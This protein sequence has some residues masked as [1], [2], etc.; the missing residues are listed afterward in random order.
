[1]KKLLL[2]LALALPMLAMTSCDDDDKVPN[3]DVTVS[4]EG[5]T[6]V[7]NTLYLVK[8]QP[9][10]ITAVT[11]KDLGGKGAVI[12]GVNYFWDYFRIGASIVSPYSMEFATEGIPAGNHLLQMTM[13]IYAVDYSPCEALL[14]YKVV[15][16]ESEDDIPSDG[17]IE[18]DPVLPASVHAIDTDDD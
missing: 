14:E 13:S 12:G 8:D 17:D 16:V 10:N 11:L 5:T 6:R 2:L 1:M 9:L 18:P 15:I 7:G 4:F 3:V